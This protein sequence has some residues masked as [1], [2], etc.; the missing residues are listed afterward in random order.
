[1]LFSLPW[2][3]Q[4]WK[5]SWAIDP[6]LDVVHSLSHSR[7]G[8]VREE[9]EVEQLMSDDIEKLRL[10]DKT[11]DNVLVL[12]FFLECSKQ[13]VPDTEP[14]SIILIQ[15][16][17]SNSAALIAGQSNSLVGEVIGSVIFF[18]IFT[19]D[20]DVRPTLDYPFLKELEFLCIKKLRI[21]A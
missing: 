17:P 16:V 20:S 4:A 8:L 10:V 7:A 6:L 15:T 1:M 3:I 12:F 19:Y 13:S 14:A 2:K 9:R 18:L 11:V 5:P 21:F